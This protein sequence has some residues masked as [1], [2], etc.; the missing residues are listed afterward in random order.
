M[1]T[2]SPNGANGRNAQGRFLPGNQGGP[3]NPFARRCA[4][5]RKAFLEAVS[6]E[7]MQ[8]IATQLVARAKGGDLAAIK[9]L[10]LWTLG[11]PPE[12][13]APDV[14][15]REVRPEEPTPPSGTAVGVEGTAVPDRARRERLAA[16]ELL[17]EVRAMRAGNGE[18]LEEAP[19]APD[20]PF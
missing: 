9:V 19:E 3:G 8:A 5:I 10:L 13:V 16:I 7:D 1:E 11:K 4:A 17:R 18:A 14:V 6:E 15:L 20:R 2:P 12:P